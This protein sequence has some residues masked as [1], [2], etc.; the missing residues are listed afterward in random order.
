M[1]EMTSGLIAM[2]ESQQTILVGIRE[3][4]RAVEKSTDKLAT[5]IREELGN[6]RRAAEALERMAR[7]EEE[8]LTFEKED[9]TERK[10]REKEE[11]EVRVKQ[12][13]ED[14]K[15]REDWKKRIWESQAFQ[16]LMLG[17]VMGFFQ[18]LGFGY[19]VNRLLPA[20][21]PQS[22]LTISSDPPA[23]ALAP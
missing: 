5:E 20:S 2:R 1:S 10:E 6:S 3:G 17:L 14:R 18:L 23:P 19:L 15:V 8:R 9:R 12:D 21:P 4:Q 13:R 16:M 11:R 7:T 22:P